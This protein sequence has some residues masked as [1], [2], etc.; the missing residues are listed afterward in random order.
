MKKIY[1]LGFVLMVLFAMTIGTVDSKSLNISAGHDATLHLLSSYDPSL[2]VNDVR[3]YNVTVNQVR[4]KGDVNDD[5][6]ITV[7]DALLYLRYS[8]GQNISP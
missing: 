5:G 1:L 8:V 3:T 4:L 2:S 6:K 7:A